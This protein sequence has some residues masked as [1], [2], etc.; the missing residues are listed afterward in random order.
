MKNKLWLTLG[1]IFVISNIVLAQTAKKTITNEDLEKFKQKRLQAEAEYKAKYKELGMPSPEE[2]EKRNRESL[3]WKQEF[4]RQAEANR[5]QS[6]DYWQSRANALRYEIYNVNGQINF[7]NNQI[8]GL[9]N[10]NPNVFTPQQLGQV[11]G[12]SYGY[13]GGR[14][15]FAQ[16]GN[17]S[18]V[19]TVNQAT[20]VQTAINAAAANPNP[21]YGT[22]L[23]S[24]GVKLVIGQ[25]NNYGRRGYGRNYGYGVP[26]A[27]NNNSS[28][29]DE[30]VSRLQYLGQVR[31]GLL[32]QWNN[33]VAE[34]H[35]AGIRITF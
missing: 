35:R 24:S 19:N 3:E 7:L 26:Y 17:R 16:R 2:L 20:S 33:L 18:Q 14:G 22:P 4:S 5:Q 10:Q 21:F 9:P 15:N 32:A 6:Q 27:V 8:A 1:F 34:A 25:N 29:R 31:A 28:N 11:S 12:G 30:L 23:Y 13:Y